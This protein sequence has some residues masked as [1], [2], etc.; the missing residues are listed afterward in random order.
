MT[1]RAGWKR[2][3]G[4]TSLEPAPPLSRG[5][6][7]TGGLEARSATGLKPPPPIP[8]RALGFDTTGA[9]AVLPLIGF[10]RQGGR[11]RGGRYVEPPARVVW[12]EAA[13]ALARHGAGAGVEAALE[14][15]ALAGRELREGGAAGLGVH[16]GT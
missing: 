3:R 4:A 10:W 6:D 8:E 12:Q 2:R 7:R 9:Q 16:V 13:L 5:N 11:H 15:C 1:A 14:R